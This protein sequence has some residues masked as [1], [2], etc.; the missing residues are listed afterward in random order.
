[1]S[2]S[3]I[4]MACHF[5]NFAGSQPSWDQ[6]KAQHPAE[7]SSPLLLLPCGQWEVQPWPGAQLLEN[8]KV[9]GQQPRVPAAPFEQNTD[10][11]S[12]VC[13][14]TKQNQSQQKEKS[15]EMGDW[16]E[17]SQEKLFL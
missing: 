13:R 17:I 16:L 12:K 4:G 1:M 15:L 6:M 9:F 7:L 8:L 5:Q 11:W 10:Q 2:L 3:S 14:R